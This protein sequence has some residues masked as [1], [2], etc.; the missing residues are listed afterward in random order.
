MNLL[1]VLSNS[2]CAPLFE[3]FS[4]L[5]SIKGFGWVTANRSMFA[6]IIQYL[7][8]PDQYFTKIFNSTNL[9]DYKNMCFLH[10]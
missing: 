2:R 3:D 1:I 4:C 7:F 6:P 5:S 9:T 10:I 8:P